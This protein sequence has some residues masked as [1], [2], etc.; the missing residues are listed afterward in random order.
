[1]SFDYV[2]ETACIQT[3]TILC[4]YFYIWEL[5][6]RLNNINLYYLSLTSVLI[7]IIIVII[8]ELL[9]HF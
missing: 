2:I 8:I 3:I 7:L 9:N 5:D 6:L 1:M 4:K